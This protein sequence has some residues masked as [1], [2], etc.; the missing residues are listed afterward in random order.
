MTSDQPTV[1]LPAQRTCPFSPPAEYERMRENAPVSRIA[2]P[3]GRTAWA[4][5]R[6]EDV[7]AMLADPRFSSDRTHPDFPVL[8]EGQQLAANSGQSLISM[9][10]PEHGA[11]RRA[12]VGEFTV[13]RMAA[14]RPRTQQ[15]VDEHVD[16]LLAG[17]RPADLVRG[18][19]LPVPSLVI[20]ELLGV[21]YADHEFFQSR[22]ARLLRRTEP[23]PERARARDELRSYLDDLVTVK[24]QAP[25]EDLLGRQILKQ[26]ETGKGDH[27]DLVSLAVLLLIAGHETTANM[28]SLGTLALLEHLR[29]RARLEEDAEAVPGAV[30]ELLRYFSI[31]DAVTARVAT[32]DVE[33]GGVVIPAGDGVLGLGNAANHDPGVYARP[34]NSTSRAARGTTWPS[35]T[36]PISASAR[37]WRG[38]GCRWSSKRCSGASRGSVSPF[39][40]A[41]CPSGTTAPYTDSTNSRSPGR[42]Y[43]KQED[44]CA[45][46]R[47][48]RAA[49]APASACSASRRS[50]TRTRRTARWSSWS[51]GRGKPNWQ[52]CGRRWR[53]APARRSPSRRTDRAALRAPRSRGSAL[54]VRQWCV[55]RPGCCP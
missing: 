33:I 54:V 12:V 53:S 35:G 19:A 10:P 37:T 40:S 3:G 26:R 38:W 11:A 49:S 42:R 45:S 36:A 55:S 48:P 43:E 1:T 4:L 50:S 5:T 30:E 17:P 25:T 44:G 32:A 13:K 31:V 18:L 28:I 7:R 8:A 14:L 51:T 24:E 15:I 41:N 29:E 27:A 6:H 52:A 46:S 16:A 21:P 20:C 2:L 22:S 23:M 9:D 39:R 47:T 34:P